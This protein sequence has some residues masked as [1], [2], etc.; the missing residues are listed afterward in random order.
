MP[1]VQPTALEEAGSV[2]DIEQAISYAAGCLD[3]TF[4]TFGIRRLRLRPMVREET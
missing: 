2:V 1:A 4:D 3:L